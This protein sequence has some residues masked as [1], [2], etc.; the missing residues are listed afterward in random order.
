MNSIF[1][2]EHVLKF[3]F[4]KYGAPDEKLQVMFFSK[5][6]NVNFQLKNKFLFQRAYD[7]TLELRMSSIIYVHTHRFYSEIITF[8]NNFNQVQL[9]SWQ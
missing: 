3:H 5:T 8:F 6:L 4:F 1:R 2:G 7:A 9:F